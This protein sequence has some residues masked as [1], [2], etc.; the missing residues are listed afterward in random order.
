MWSGFKHLFKQN[1]V[2]YDAR[3][4]STV[5]EPP[6]G[7][8]ATPTKQ[9]TDASAQTTFAKTHSVPLLTARS[10]RKAQSPICAVKLWPHQEAVLARCLAIESAPR[11]AKTI[12]K[13]AAR[14]EKKDN[15]P[16]FDQV[17]IGVMNDPPGSGKTYAILSIIAHDPMTEDTKTGLKVRP[18]NLIVVPQ[19]IYGQ[20]ETAINS[21]YPKGCGI[22]SLCCN[23][24]AEVT[25]FYENPKAFRR[26][27]I[28]LVNDI[29]AE[30][31]A[32]SLHDNKVPVQ[33]LIIDEI[34][35][36]QERLFTPINAKH[37]WLVS[38]SFIHKDDTTVGPYKINNADI[39]GIFCKCDTEF[40]AD[41]L[42]F[43]N[44]TAEKIICEDNEIVLFKDMF[45][46]LAYSGLQAGD[47]RILI[48]EIGKSFNPRVHTLP[49]IMR[50]HIE[51]LRR[52]QE[53]I[54][55]H[56]ITLEERDLSDE[57]LSN[58]KQEMNLLKRQLARADELEARLSKYVPS[59]PTKV[60]AHVFNTMICKRILNAP[61]SKWLL[62]NDNASSLFET[63]D[64]LREKGIRCV[65][66]DG[67]S[68]EEVSKS[69]KKY[70]TEN[71]QVLLLNSK[72]E[73]AGMN[74]ENTT[75]LLFMH[76]T[77]PTLVEQVVGRAQRYGRVGSL[78]IIG[79]FNAS[80]DPTLAKY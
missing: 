45:S 33:R 18:L 67:G 30:T 26:F 22:T 4:D 75:H 51:E 65:L 80:E 61:T 16:Q 28:V 9:D 78:H 32:I 58:I 17:P 70:K 23:N 77:A 21:I 72:M 2:V 25:H 46:P 69:I 57:E 73:G 41:Q 50:I 55:A 36:V 43:E 14:Y 11:Y 66:L 8:Q 42:K 53:Q 3:T 59:D 47:K 29:Y 54:D 48:K 5:V 68:S 31:L 74:L 63:Y 62:F 38:A 27:N 71:V 79:L 1:V 15:V 35:N 12:I 52:S 10:P 34:D 44:P 24:Y 20:W 37:V 19:N 6:S 39:A 40:I 60:K 64:L 76:A 56:N 13:N 49:D 7:K